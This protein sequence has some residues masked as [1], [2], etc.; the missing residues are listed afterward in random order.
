VAVASV[1]AQA[2]PVLYAVNSAGV[3]FLAD[4]GDGRVVELGASG[5]V[6][7]EVINDIAVDLDGHV[8]GITAS[9]LYA[10]DRGTGMATAIGPH[11]VPGANALEIG[12]DG[13][14]YAAGANGTTLFTLDPETGASTVFG[15]MGLISDGGLA[16]SGDALFLSSAGSLVQLDLD[17]GG[18]GTV[19][20]PIGF[21]FVFGLA[22]GTDGVLYGSSNDDLIE[23]DTE[24]GAGAFLRQLPIGTIFGLSGGTGD[25]CDGNGMIDLQEVV[26]G[27]IA[28]CN[29]N[30]VPDSCDIDG[31]RSDLNGNGVPDGCEDCDG[32]GVPDDQDLAGGAGEDCNGNGVLDECD[33]ATATCFDCNLNGVPDECE[34][35]CN[36][37]G[38]DDADEL[39]PD[40]NVN[41]LP[42]D[43]DVSSIFE[44]VSG[45]IVGSGVVSGFP[46]TAV[47]TDPPVAVGAVTISLTARGDLDEPG[48]F[49]FVN[50]NDVFLGS[51]FGDANACPDEPDTRA[52]TVPAADFN[53]A[54]NSGDATIS[55]VP[56]TGMVQC[57]GGSSVVVGVRYRAADDTLDC[58]GNGEPDACDIAA[59]GSIDCNGNGLP[60]ECEL[61]CNGNGV[62]DD[63]DIGSKTSPDCNGN[64]IPD[65]C[66]LGTPVVLE[67][68]PRTPLG[69]GVQQDM[70]FGAVAPAGTDV[71]ITVTVRADL[72]APDEFVFAF[73]N[74]Q[75]LGSFFGPDGAN[76][77]FDPNVAVLML[78]PDEYNNLLDSGELQVSVVPNSSVQIECN[79]MQNPSF[80]EVRV[81]YVPADLAD[82]NGNGVPDGCDLAS[83]ASS[84]LNGNS[85][86]DDCECL[87]DTDGSGQVNVDDLVNVILD[88]G[89]DGSANGTDV[90]NDGIVGVDDLLLIIL[91]YGDCAKK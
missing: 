70:E 64:A 85:R 19:L 52:L 61:D 39:R 74:G 43:C 57:A 47:V 86:P 87:G 78:G 84:D 30:L 38:V 73:A 34:N 91:G 7:P 49:V 28:D 22:T 36:C 89:T 67:S 1:P 31:G 45:E 8:L 77:P 33:L 80:A 6:P 63:C 51:L 88:W 2:D 42:D 26:D 20:G 4:A 5:L 40:C 76:C 54:V 37:N 24:T 32:N 59:G 68:G 65:E 75:L 27:A 90:N 81:E 15:D 46:A 50:L 69:S 13:T 41:G 53:A 14:L 58:N 10:I 56:N 25:D 21:P 55:I 12:P 82:C 44:S 72:E 18:A 62:P 11:D 79:P 48:E 23:I 16:F 66:E 35:D 83:G 3:L 17:A 29:G 71:S 60:D 9:S